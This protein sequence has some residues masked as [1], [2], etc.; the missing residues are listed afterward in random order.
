MLTKPAIQ[1]ELVLECIRAEYGLN[2]GRLEFLPLGADLGTAVYR[3]TATDGTAYFLK[4]RSGEFCEA[5]LS[6]PRYLNDRGI[7]QVIPALRTR[8]HQLWAELT[9]YKVMLFPFIEGRNGS[10][11]KL[12]P[13]QWVDLGG[14]VKRFHAT[15]IPSGITQGVRRED[16]SPR[17]RDGVKEYLGRIAQE[18]FTDS[19]AIEMAAYLKTKKAEILRIVKRAGQLAILL[20]KQS[21]KFILCHADLHI[22]NLLV[23][24]SGR[25]YIVDWDTLIYAPRERDLMF[26]GGGL[27][28]SGRRPQDE[29]RLFYMG[30]GQ[31]P[32]DPAALAYYRYERVIE[33]IAAFCEQIFSTNEGGD[34][35]QKALEYIKSNFLP[36]GTIA[37]AVA[38]DAMIPTDTVV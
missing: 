31:A 24:E 10:E 28:D 3:V 29:E 22:W 37:R 36:D 34:D 18:T 25:F 8:S 23:A 12:T 9:P 14:A 16:Y 15:Y 13:Q 38:A 26:I 20:Q 4:L 32:I 5:S 30:Y 1:D 33:D 21:P 2:A 7:R 6:V 35:R 17:W 11:K 27:G 19:V